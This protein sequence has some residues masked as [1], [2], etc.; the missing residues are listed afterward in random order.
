MDLSDNEIQ[1]RKFKL[2]CHTL[3]S[4]I[5]NYRPGRVQHISLPLL[6]GVGTR[7]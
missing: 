6:L 1:L 2:D 7:I 5:M 4:N 3:G